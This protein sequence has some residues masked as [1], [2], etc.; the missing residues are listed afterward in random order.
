M[1]KLTHN[2]SK[3][4]YKSQNYR[5]LRRKHSTHICDPGF[6]N[7]FLDMIPKAQAKKEHIDKLGFPKIKNFVHQKTQSR[8]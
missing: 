8:Q 2:G 7:G 4:T 6:S 3:S 1:Q 5:S